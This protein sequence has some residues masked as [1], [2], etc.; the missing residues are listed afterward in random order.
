MPYEYGPNR[1]RLTT[2][3]QVQIIKTGGESNNLNVHH[4]VNISIIIDL[5]GKFIDKII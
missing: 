3:E 4:D 1:N 5:L 2:E